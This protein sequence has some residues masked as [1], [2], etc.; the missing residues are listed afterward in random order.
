M[1]L[2]YKSRCAHGS[3]IT[4]IC[5][6]PTTSKLQGSGNA[7]RERP[8]LGVVDRHQSTGDGPWVPL[9]PRLLGTLTSSNEGVQMAHATLAHSEASSHAF[10]VAVVFDDRSSYPCA[11][12][13]PWT[14]D[15]DQISLQVVFCYCTCMRPRN[16]STFSSLLSCQ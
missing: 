6:R 2:S 10:K 4:R 14:T 13:F 16:L 3:L 15:F 12:S 9:L 11:W 5:S 8:R 7:T 1:F